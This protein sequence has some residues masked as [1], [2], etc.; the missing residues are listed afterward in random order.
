MAR[1]KF[2]PARGLEEQLA[3]MLAPDVRRIAQQVEVE[4]K[5]LAP[6]V[7]KWVTTGD[8]KVRPTHVEANGQAVPDNLR[9]K[10]TS[11]WTGTSNTAASSP[12]P[13]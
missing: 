9:F 1:A 13:T 5:R 7:K 10:L 6:P 3:R 8:D 12:T 2:T 11:T 4:A